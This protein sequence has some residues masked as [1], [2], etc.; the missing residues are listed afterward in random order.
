[1][2]PVIGITCCNRIVGTEAAQAVMDRYVRAVSHYA[3]V[4]AL[5]IPAIPDLMTAD[6]VI[7]R[8]DG[9]LLTGSPS[10]VGAVHYGDG[11]GDGPFDS[12]RDTM[13]MQLI[14]AA[15][16]VGKPVF[17]ICRGL[18]EINVALGGT[19]RR[20]ASS[21]AELIAHHAPSD[22]DFNAM[23]D[24]DHVVTLSD[25]GLLA[26]AYAR[27]ELIVNSVHFQAIGTLSLQLKV[28]AMAPDGV[29]EAVSAII[30]QTPI[31]AVQWHPEWKT[32]QIA[33]RQTFFKLLGAM[34]RA[35]MRTN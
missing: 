14:K 7:A 9:I 12:A 21:S 22:V 11:D 17:G 10:N 26:T 4:A 5:L 31:L 15:I 2:R 16:A 29:V 34:L 8:V 25:G 1:M 19:L 23:F 35:T 20:D 28:E 27:S 24:H 13:T 30:N 18:Q 32:D 6:E 3:D 33:D